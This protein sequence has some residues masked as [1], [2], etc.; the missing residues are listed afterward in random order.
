MLV[1][2]ETLCQY[3]VD[4]MKKMNTHYQQEVNKERLKLH[5]SNWQFCE[6]IESEALDNQ[7]DVNRG[8][9]QQVKTKLREE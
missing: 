7:N 1:D 5:A 6:K 4:K 2:A 8:T 3:H 9:E